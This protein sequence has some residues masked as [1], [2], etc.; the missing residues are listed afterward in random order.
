MSPRLK[1]EPDPLSRAYACPNCGMVSAF[2]ERVDDLPED[3]PE[4]ELSCVD[5]WGGLAKPPCKVHYWKPNRK[6]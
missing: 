2:H 3:H 6:G 5:K 1:K 4:F